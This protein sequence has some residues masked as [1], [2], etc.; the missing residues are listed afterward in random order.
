LAGVV[1]IFNVLFIP[2]SNVIIVDKLGV[3]PPKVVANVP[4]G[5]AM[6]AHTTSAVGQNLTTLF[7]SNF[8]AL[9]NLPATLTYQNNGLLFGSK[10]I[11]QT[12]QARLQ[13]KTLQTNLGIYYKDC[14]MPDLITGVLKIDDL[15]QSNNLYQY[16]FEGHNPNPAIESIYQ[17][18]VNG[19]VTKDCVD[20][21]AWLKPLIDTGVVTVKNRLAKTMNRA[22]TTG[23]AKANFETQ[24]TDAY[25]K[26]AIAT[27]LSDASSILRHN[28]LM[29][30]VT[31]VHGLTGL[32]NGDPSQ[33]MFAMAQ[34][35]ATAS[36]N[37]SMISSG[38]LAQETLPMFRNILQAVL[39]GI[40]PLWLLTLLLFQGQALFKAIKTYALALL[41]IELWPPLF[42]V[43]NYFMTDATAQKMAA[44]ATINGTAASLSLVTAADIYSGSIS[45]F[46]IA[47]Y[48]VVSI[49]LIASAIVFG[50]DKIAG[51][52]TNHL[53]QVASAMSSESS[54]LTKG[55]YSSGIART[56]DYFF[57]R[58]MTMPDVETTNTLGGSYRRNANTGEFAA[59]TQAN[60][61]LA[62]N[63]AIAESLSN[64]YTDQATQ[65]KTKSEMLSQQ[66]SQSISTAAN[67]ALRHTISAG[68]SEQSG[69]RTGNDTQQSMGQQLS[70]VA[71]TAQ[72]I[73]KKTGV[74]NQ[75]A[76]S[77]AVGAAIGGDF[78]GFKSIIAGVKSK[79]K[80]DDKKTIDNTE[81]S[82]HKAGFNIGV[83][84]QI[85]ANSQE[86]LSKVFEEAQN[87]LRQSGITDTKSVTDAYTN[88]Q[89]YQKAAQKGDI[90]A[91]SVDSSLQQ[92]KTYQASAQ[93]SEQEAHTKQT[94]ASRT[95]QLAMQINSGLSN[96]FAEH[97]YKKYGGKIPT[98]VEVQRQEMQSFLTNYA[99]NR[100]TQA[101]S[102]WFP[103]GS[104]PQPFDW[105][106]GNYGAM[107]NN[108]LDTSS[109]S[110]PP[111]PELSK[112]AKKNALQDQANND[113]KVPNRLAT[114]VVSNDVARAP[115]DALSK[116]EV[117]G[118]TSVLNN[119]F[120]AAKSDKEAAE[121]EVKNDP[122]FKA[123]QL[124]DKS[125]N[126]VV[127]TIFGSE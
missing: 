114:T 105:K 66:A 46:A 40:F 68:M 28:V 38:Q 85:A 94:M 74:T 108:N 110:M 14:V 106:N 119:E 127:N 56:D 89:F 3:Q 42:A 39:Y 126:K 4:Y 83:K 101:D 87:Q 118:L 54:Q 124:M 50:M 27:G 104:K 1:L 117:K 111:M 22:V 25:A 15:E 80:P 48:L 112:D 23:M 12:M 18:K 107:I 102:A 9:G 45:P 120:D 67:Q 62:V 24:T 125:M 13:D 6:L 86:S 93:Q 52:A 64:Q 90:T 116:T 92:A 10:L 109:T 82:S 19:L 34:Q 30:L 59:F 44:E 33:L 51:V 98:D 123:K 2:K 73:A 122:R 88:S 76:I 21:Q 55:N 11:A 63:G 99:P 60:S 113:R 121:Q 70:S 91:R 31:D 58:N 75:E 71:Q 49:P 7:E 61:S 16:L 17:D 79:I 20:A 32:E 57:G 96:P 26:Y 103:L 35:S 8:M 95:A 53:A 72:M 37:L 84:G 65:A 29:N 43:M 100:P 78:Q 115:A 97:L 36:T 47:N 77:S 41:W 5:L 69:S 81:S